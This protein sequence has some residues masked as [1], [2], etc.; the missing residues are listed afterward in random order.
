M[1]EQSLISS[2]KGDLPTEREFERWLTQ[3]A[4]FSRSQARTIITSGFKSLPISKPGAGDEG[5][6][7]G[8]IDWNA[9]GAQLASL[10]SSITD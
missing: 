8:A 7:S 1:N 9:F 2:V 4:G 6:S 3:D 5:A 10:R